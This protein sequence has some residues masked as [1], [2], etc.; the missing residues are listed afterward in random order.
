MKEQDNKVLTVL[1]AFL[2]VIF[3]SFIPKIN[4][5]KVVVNE[6]KLKN[7]LHSINSSMDNNDYKKI[8]SKNLSNGNLYIAYKNSSGNYKTYFINKKD[9]KIVD[10]STNLKQ[11]SVDKL[12]EVENKLLNLKY[13]KFI[14]EGIN[15]S[16]VLKEYVINDYDL[17]IYYKNVITNPQY[18]E[19]ISLK[20]NYNEIDNLLNYDH[21]LSTD[22]QNESAY[23]YDPNKKYIAFTFDDGPNRKNTIDIVNY[24]NDN[25]MRAT[26]FMVG[27][28]L[29][30]NADI[31]KYVYDNKMEIGSHSWSHTNMRRQKLD[32]LVKDID[33]ANETYKNIIGENFKLI[34]PPYGAFNNKIKNTLDFSFIIWS[35]DTLDW[36][37]KDSDRLYDFVINNVK[38]GD[39]VLMH[40]LQY[41]TKV[42][43]EK[44]LP[45]L[46]V[47]GYQVVTVSELASIKGV[48]LE[49][50]HAYYDINKK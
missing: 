5:K 19:I 16:N 50:H 27:N 26:F 12:N 36:K 1:I 42:A 3:L 41:S 10:F 4:D 45:E 49:N 37:Y 22:Y 6:Q 8:S 28:L 39:V 24:L 31:V 17:V 32:K 15:N 48:N 2:I 46:Y 35:V 33:K 38:D 9:S 18:N 21:L 11:N 34:R 23:I 13:P 7:T 47:R 29:E 30:N 25:K 43:M 44:I 14:V 20:I 40:D